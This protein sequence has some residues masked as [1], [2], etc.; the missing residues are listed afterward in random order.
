M[1]TL[2][3]CRM[4]QTPASDCYF[5]A[6]TGTVLA[7]RVAQDPNIIRPGRCLCTVSSDEVVA[8]LPSLFDEI[9]ARIDEPPLQPE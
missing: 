2:T 7:E 5:C 1:Q 3:A 6:G 9:L 4:A 8:A